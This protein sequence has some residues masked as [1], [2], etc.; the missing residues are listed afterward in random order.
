MSPSGG[1]ITERRLPWSFF[2]EGVQGG[3]G[4]SVQ[5]FRRKMAAQHGDLCGRDPLSM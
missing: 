3:R 5:G 2:H 4:L 1:G